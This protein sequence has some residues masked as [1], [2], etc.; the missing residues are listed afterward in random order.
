MAKTERLYVR[1]DEDLKV[2]AQEVADKENRT[3]SN[4][5]ETLIKEDLAER[6]KC[7]E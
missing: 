7:N 3:L 4:Y 6:R 2:K 5:I 1:I